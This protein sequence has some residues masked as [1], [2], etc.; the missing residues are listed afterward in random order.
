MVSRSTLKLLIDELNKHQIIWGIGGSYLLQ[1]YELYSEPQD[2]DIWVQ[3]C[4]IQKIRDIFKNYCEI[5]SNLPLPS[6]LH[7]K[8]QY[9]DIEVD[10]VACFIVKPNQY[11]FKYNINSNRIKKITLKNGLE[12]PCTFLEDWYIIYKLLKRDDKAEL[13]HELFKKKKININDEAIRIAVNNSDNTLPIQVKK[14][15][16]KL[17]EDNIQLSIFDE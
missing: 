9:H 8:M 16:F 2:L 15:A 6:N 12:V 13:I 5:E 14:D 1:I 10:F 17:I 7:F 4:D 3:P 11:S